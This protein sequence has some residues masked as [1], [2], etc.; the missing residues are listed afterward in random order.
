MYALVATVV[1]SE[2]KGERRMAE[3]RA[4]GTG[5]AAK[6]TAA[7]RCDNQREP[8]TDEEGRRAESLPIASRTDSQSPA[9]HGR[10]MLHVAAYSC[11][12][13]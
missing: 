1:W 11:S 10:M 7:S 9:P 8:T 4:G 3:R 12:R 2:N 13:A 6:K 5:G